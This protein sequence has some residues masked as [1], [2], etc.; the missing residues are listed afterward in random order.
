ML[1]VVARQA[2]GL[3]NALVLH[4]RLQNRAGF[5]LADDTALDFLPWRLVVGE[6]VTALGGKR[7]V[8]LRQ[9]LA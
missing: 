6:L 4:G 8:T 5:H 9:F 1:M 3:G 7:L 2:L